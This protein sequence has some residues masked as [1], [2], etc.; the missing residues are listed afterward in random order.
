M[1]QKPKSAGVRSR[2]RSQSLASQ[3]PN[4]LPHHNGRKTTSKPTTGNGSSHVVLPNWLALPIKAF[5]SALNW[6]GRNKK[7]IGFTAAF[8]ALIY[9]PFTWHHVT[10]YK[11]AAACKDIGYTQAVV[12]R[13]GCEGRSDCTAIEEGLTASFTLATA[14]SAS[15]CDY[16]A[17]PPAPHTLIL[18]AFHAIA[19]E[20]P[21]PEMFESPPLQTAEAE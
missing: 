9:A 16:L 2:L 5:V 12:T 15:H 13:W 11:L 14:Y 4:T 1:T 8:V 6:A 17:G 3:K 7:P 19:P 18:H 10:T 20:M 21:D